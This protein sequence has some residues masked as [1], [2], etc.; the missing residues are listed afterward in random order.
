MQEVRA[1][2]LEIAEFLEVSEESALQLAQSMFSRPGDADIS[3]S[4]DEALDLDAIQGG[5]LV[6]LTAKRLY[7]FQN[8]LDSMDGIAQDAWRTICK[9]LFD[10]GNAFLENL[11]QQATQG[12]SSLPRQALTGSFRSKEAH[13]AGNCRPCVFNLRG[14]CKSSA[15]ECLYCHEEGHSKTKRASHR[16]RK[17]RK[18]QR[19]A[20]TPSPD[21]MDGMELYLAPPEYYFSNPPVRQS[22]SSYCIENWIQYGK[23]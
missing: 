4:R 23:D 8:T 7:G 6:E 11:A 14:I 12:S 19:R 18:E 3:L 2:I 17:Q 10:S 5:P 22:F 21:R 15:E 20:R 16:V 13:D 1:E 9:K